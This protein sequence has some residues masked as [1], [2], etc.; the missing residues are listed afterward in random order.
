MYEMRCASPSSSRPLGMAVSSAKDPVHVA[1]RDGGHNKWTFVG[2]SN[3]VG[4]QDLVQCFACGKDKRWKHFRGRRE[5]DASWRTLRCSACLARVRRNPELG[6]GD[7]LLS[8]SYRL[9]LPFTPV[10]HGYVLVKRDEYDN[11]VATRGTNA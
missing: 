11:M 2:T 3:P 4:G 1:C 5:R 6:T 10:P 8:L 9:D 7:I